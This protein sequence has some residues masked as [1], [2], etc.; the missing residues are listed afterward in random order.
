MSRTVEVRIRG[1]ER[2]SFRMELGTADSRAEQSALYRQRDLIRRLHARGEFD[3]LDALKAGRT[4]PA[5][6]ERL[7]DEWGIQDYRKHL[8][9]RA[10]LARHKVPTLDDHVA[11]WLESIAKDGTRWTYRKHLTRLREFVLEGQRLGDLPWNEAAP[12]HVI[13]DIKAELRKVLA[14]NTLR[15]VIAAWSA[16][17]EWAIARDESEAA[18][19]RRARLLEINPVRTAKLW[20]PIEITRHRFLSWGEFQELLKVAPPAMRAQY[21]TLCLAGLR[22][23]EFV[24]LPPA[25]VRLPT[26]LHVGPWGSWRPKGYPRSK[27]GVRDIPLHRDLLP[28]LEEHRARYAG[29]DRFFVNPVTGERWA[30]STFAKRLQTD[31]TAAGMTFGQWSRAGGTLKRKA[32]GVTAHTMRHTLASWLAQND[33]QLLKIAA[34]LGDTVDTVQKHYAHLLPKDLDQALNRIG[35]SGSASGND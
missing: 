31:V 15:T 25:H 23:D 10:S 28:L 20:E 3:V 21:A 12:R 14:G 11:R 30:R 26:H 5:E 29:E 1:V 22:L 17:Y 4:T 6:L 32:E 8:D 33:I 34:I 16:F 13:K 19:E 18:H 7:V 35:E 2:P 9:L 27:H 24:Q